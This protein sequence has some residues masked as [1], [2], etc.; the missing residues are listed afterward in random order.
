MQ[1]FQ[2]VVKNGRIVLDQP[3]DLPEGEVVTL[4]ALEELLAEAEHGGG[5]DSDDGEAP[6]FRFELPQ[7]EFRKPKMMDARALL[8]ELKSL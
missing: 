6:I 4:I 7:R 1:P 5:D 8:D 2:A 3:T